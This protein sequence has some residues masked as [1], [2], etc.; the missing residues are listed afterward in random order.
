M[1]L[2]CFVVLA[3]CRIPS[4]LGLPCTEDAHCDA[5]Q[6]CANEVCAEGSAPGTSET[7]DA[8]T[9][10]ATTDPVTSAATGTTMPALTTEPDSSSTMAVSAESTSSTGPAC[11]AAV[12]SCD[13][14]DVLFLI[15]NSA[16][17]EEDFSTLLPA[18]TDFDAIAEAFIDGLCSYHLGVTTTETMQRYEAPECQVRGALHR[19][20]TLAPEGGCFEDDHPPY[21]TED[22]ALQTLGCLFPVGNHHD[23]DEKQIDTVLAALAP[24]INAAGECNDGFLRDDAAL[25]VVIVSDEDDDDDSDEL[26]EEPYRTGS[27]GG[28]SE[29]FDALTAIKPATNLGVVLIGG[30]QIGG[31]DWSAAPGEDDG[32]G[33]EYPDRLLTLLQYFSGTGFISHIQ[34]SN[35]CGT[36]ADLIQDIDAI[37]SVVTAVCEDAVFE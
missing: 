20:S 12:G 18:F 35:L 15:D 25:I 37:Q 3:A 9:M 6:Y 31:C 14:L 4:T 36:A 1:R 7:T 24:E 32:T 21:I 17:M 19:S 27:A 2:G 23:D 33:A 11:G 28:P 34:S 30:T 5:G 10:V 26:E 22:D 29:W 16:S 8:T 13:K